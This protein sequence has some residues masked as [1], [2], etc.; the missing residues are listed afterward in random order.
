MWKSD[1]KPSVCGGS[2]GPRRPF[3]VFQEPVC[4]GPPRRHL[5]G[6]HRRCNSSPPRF[7]QNGSQTGRSPA[8]IRRLAPAGRQSLEQGAPGAQLTVNPP[9]T[10]Y[11]CCA[12][13]L[14]AAEQSLQIQ[15]S[16]GGLWG[17]LGVS[18]ELW[19]SLGISGG[20]WGSLGI[21]LARL[22]LQQPRRSHV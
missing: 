12:K 8:G 11:F 16:Y 21:S 19:G 17:S 14:P 4:V 15:R 1:L 2:V 9:E 20:L 10:F 7:V 13:V 18:G 6:R 22:T 3:H 5:T